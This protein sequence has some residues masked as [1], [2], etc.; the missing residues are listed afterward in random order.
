MVLVH[1]HRAGQEPS[2]AQIPFARPRFKS[3][4]LDWRGDLH[5]LLTLQRVLLNCGNY[6]KD[7]RFR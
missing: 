6:W 1:H 2:L 7:E 5:P 4:N 3:E